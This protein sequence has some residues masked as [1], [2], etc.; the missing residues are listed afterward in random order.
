MFCV[1][2]GHAHKVA[3]HRTGLQ[4]HYPYSAAFL[5][6]AVGLLLCRRRAGA[7]MNSSM[8]IQQ[9]SSVAIVCV[10]IDYQHEATNLW[11]FADQA[12][13]CTACEAHERKRHE[14]QGCRAVPTK[15]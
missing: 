2:I 7:A 1:A 11:N 10:G 6:R 13:H 9:Q 3:A 4:A 15:N 8:T 5:A 12:E 14:E